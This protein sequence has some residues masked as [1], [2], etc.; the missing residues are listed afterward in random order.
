LLVV[1]A[2][3]LPKHFV[4]MGRIQL[5]PFL[6]KNHSSQKSNDMKTTVNNL[7]RLMA[8]SA[9]V[10]TTSCGPDA[11]PEDLPCLVTGNLTLTD[12]NPDGVDYVIDCEM[13]I[14]QGLL[15]IEQG[16][17]IEFK[18]GASLWVQ[19]NAAIAV[20]GTEEAPVLM[21]GTQSGA[22]W[23]GIYISSNDSRNKIAHLDLRN[24]GSDNYFSDVFG[25]FIYDAKVGIAVK[26]KTDITHTH[27]S[28]CGGVGIIYGSG[29]TVTQFDSNRITG[30][31]IYPVMMYAG[32]LSSNIS[33]ANSEFLDNGEN[34]IA[35]YSL[36][37]NN[38]VDNAV[39]M[40]EAP[41]PYLAYHTLAFMK[42]VSFEAG[43]E[44]RVS[45]GK[46]LSSY[47]ENTLWSINGTADNPVN[48]KGK[49]ESVAGFWNGM[50]VG[51][52]S[53]GV[54]TYLSVSGG[55]YDFTGINVPFK[56]N[57]NVTDTYESHLTLNQCSSALNS[58]T[59]DVGV[60]IGNGNTTFANNSVGLIVC[61]D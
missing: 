45:Q 36:S 39:T 57:I 4:G 32:N 14:S 33:F 2:Y 46:T 30:C 17:T 37:S 26:G 48:I 51:G 3:A 28:N 11:V 31:A 20:N 38:E 40:N 61:Q 43:V 49:N 16:V 24:T 41:I 25:G 10:F 1:A 6:L 7:F 54:F 13:E 59:C 22:S 58:S 35:L 29:A 8:A 34:Y 5:L 15:T 53:T 23:K 12:H 27:I 21:S 18:N 60:R 44:M 9:I 42:N 56:A 19:E 50:L 52:E 55:G 47:G